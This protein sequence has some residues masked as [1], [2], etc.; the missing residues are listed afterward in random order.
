MCG[1][2]ARERSVGAS[3]GWPRAKC[4]L[5]LFGFAALVAPHPVFAQ[6]GQTQQDQGSTSLP[7]IVVIGTTPM[8]PVRRAP[9][10]P[11]KP[12][13]NAH[14]TNSQPAPAASTAVV[15]AIDADKIPSNVQTLS[16]SAFD[17][18]TTP[19]LLQ[20][21]S[22][23]L[24]GV[25]LSG[26]TGNQFQLDINY[27]GFTSSPV[28]GTP[29][30]LAVYQNG[31]RIN[32]VFGDTVNWDLVPEKAI[33]QMTLVPSNPVYGLNALGGAMSLEMKNGF[34]Y[35]GVEGEILGGS[36]GRFGA[37][38]QAGGQNGNMS[39]YITADAIDDGGWRQDSPSRVR[40]VYADVGARGD[41]Y[42]EFHVSFT[43]ADNTFGAA[44][45]TPI[46]MLSQNWASVYTIPQTTENKLAFL[47][48]TGSWKPT[49]TL[50]LQGNLYY[51]GFW[52]RH[53]D[54]NGTDATAC[55]PP[56]TVLC[57]PDLD[58]SLSP[59]ITTSGQT[60]DATGALGSSVLGEIDRTWTSTNSFGGS[61]QGTSTERVFGH[62]NNLVLG[63]SVDRGLANF[64]TTS[65]LSTINAD[66]FPVA[67]GTGLYI[68]Q[69]SGDVAPVQLGST[70]LYTGFYGID[71]FDVTPRLSV[72]AGGRYNIA[73]L[74]LTDETGND[75]GLNSTHLYSRFNPTAGAAYKVAP[76]VTIYGNYSEANRAPTPLELGCA[77][78]MRPCL[79][80]NALVGDP[81]LNQVASH[82]FEGGVRGHFDIPKGML[83]WSVGAFHALNTNDILSVASP[84]P[85]HEYFQ[86]AGNTVRQGIEAQA[87]YK[88]DRWTVHANYTYVDAR[89]SDALTLSSPNNP[90]ADGNGNIFVTPG[91]HLTGIPDFR[92]KAGADYQVTDPWKVGADLNVV[93]S[94]WLVGD[95]ANQ[96]PKVPA[97]WTV[98]L[99]TSYKLSKSIEA[100][101][102]VRN[103]FDRHYY[104][105]GTFFETDSFPYLNLSDPRTFVP[106]MPLAVYAGLRGTF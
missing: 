50:T 84:I 79:I 85:G 69:P 23:G 68:D 105:Y 5:L 2:A 51:R 91:D 24:P 82:T 7:E 99:H 97:Y 33:N 58:G 26:Q 3:A 20:A 31:V 38:V 65:E 40:R 100:F 89:F 98:D 101:G 62:D 67:V 15:G 78:P 55:P 102:L 29:Q 52:Q 17:H 30:G 27:R 86:N 18:S 87:S 41:N 70:A 42:T 43:G 46:E 6:Q 104:V 56:S 25:A 80:D 73:Q 66:Q 21:M 72:T 1:V 53:A 32:E 77:D 94:Q 75:P 37:S 44:A 83:N 35:H 9:V 11:G 64:T 76:N 96:N 54:G 106:G 10:R 92:F 49:D 59:L 61:L 60:V 13:A 36:Y 47:T 81:N 12:S 88:Q 103:L 14:A 16:A 95:E 93:G 48:G 71:T 22:Q 28:I 63:M 34:T 45:A 57:F 39:G 90:F 74:G 4:L 8:P 19:D